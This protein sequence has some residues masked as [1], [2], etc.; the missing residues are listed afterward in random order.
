MKRKLFFTAVVLVA[1][2]AI[3]GCTRGNGGGTTGQPTAAGDSNLNPVGTFP[4]ARNTIT[5]TGLFK[6]QPY[7][8]ELS[9]NDMTLYLQKMSNIKLDLQTVPVDGYAD[10][11]RILL[12]TGDYPEVIFS[13]AATSN[14]DITNYGITEKIYI[15]ITAYVKN[16]M[17]NLALRLKE[18]P[19]ILAGIT[20][21]DG[22][23][24]AFPDFEGQVGH[25]AVYDKLWINAAWLTKLGVSM[26]KTPAELRAA[27]LAFKTKD[28][29]GNGKADEVPLSG[30][31]NTWAAEPYLAIMNAFAYLD[32]T[33]LLRLKNGV[34]TGCANT[35][36]IR[37]G[38]RFLADL[39]KDGLIDPA[40]LTQDLA[41]LGQLGNANPSVLGSFA[42]GHIAMALDNNNLR[43][44]TDYQPVLPLSGP[45]GVQGVPVYGKMTIQGGKTAITNKAKNPEAVARMI[46]LL[47][48]ENIMMDYSSRPSLLPADAGTKGFTG[49]VAKFKQNPDWPQS[50]GEQLNWWAGMSTLG[51]IKDFKLY[52]QFSGNVY[53]PA[54]Y[55]ARLIRDTLEYQKFPA[56]GDQIMPMW[57]P[58]DKSSA[59]AVA[60]T[61]IRDYVK[62]SIVEF[63]TGTKD[64]D[65]DWASYLNG[66]EMLGYSQ[67]VK[68]YSTAYFE[69]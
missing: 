22:N 2:I 27:L 4:I 41:Q 19:E 62:T 64:V 3:A 18:M 68:D 33:T 6:L 24:Y 14:N 11:L 16:S 29:N 35:P 36:G 5:V 20:A 26:P 39:Y 46:D 1:A 31:V 13:D 53:A 52:L 40:S 51:Q 23:M 55:E 60:F 63:I 54:N 57:A 30:A 7:M 58:A 69:K 37:E 56:D 10:K 15:P 61:S 8:V 49:Y 47:Y 45:R 32:D 66:L 17:P 12:S 25:Q 34:F 67:Y 44:M 48:A 65:K 9:K 21:P 28:P 42:A 38:L 50:K 59:L 43:L